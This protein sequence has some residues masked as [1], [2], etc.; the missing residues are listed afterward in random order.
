M[1][2]SHLELVQ[3]ELSDA[4]WAVS[5]SVP[6]PVQ[7]RDQSGF[8]AEGCCLSAVSDGEEFQT[9]YYPTQ[10]CSMLQTHSVS[11]TPNCSPGVSVGGY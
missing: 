10:L 11:H 4:A 1:W 2:S 7:G 5:S 8:K 6:D 3:P 9:D